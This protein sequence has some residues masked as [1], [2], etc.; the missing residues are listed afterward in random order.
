MPIEN[1]AQRTTT[2]SLPQGSGWENKNKAFL[3]LST[4]VVALPAVAITTASDISYDIE[5]H[6]GS[7]TVQLNARI[8]GESANGN[9]DVVPGTR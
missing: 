6:R 5:H 1:T 3:S 4:A 8:S 7:H 2:S 9:V